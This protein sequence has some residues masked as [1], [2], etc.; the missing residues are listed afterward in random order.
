MISIY[1]LKKFTSYCLSTKSLK[2]YQKGCQFICHLI[3]GRNVKH[4]SLEKVYLILFKYEKFKVL[5]KGMPV[6]RHLITGRNDKY[7]SLEKVYLILFKYEKFKV[8]PKGMPVHLP[9]N[10]R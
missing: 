8:L 3:T 2:F 7:L 1:R 10:N 4:L 6:H 5:Q 9:P